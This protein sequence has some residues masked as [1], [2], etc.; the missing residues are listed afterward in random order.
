MGDTHTLPTIPHTFYAEDYRD[1][2]MDLVARRLIRKYPLL[3][4]GQRFV[5][6][7]VVFERKYRGREDYA[8]IGF[9][10]GG[11]PVFQRK[12]FGEIRQWATGKSGDPVD[13]KEPITILKT[14]A[15]A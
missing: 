15:P 11:R 8:F 7:S 13:I 4:R 2:W 5:I 3:S 1:D 6:A 9:D 14:E 12:E 10:A